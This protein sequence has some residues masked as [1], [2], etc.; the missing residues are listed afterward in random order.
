[1]SELLNKNKV[2]NTNPHSYKSHPGYEINYLI[3]AY[4]LLVLAAGIIGK[5]CVKTICGKFRNIKPNYK[6]CSFRNGRLIHDN[7]S[8]LRD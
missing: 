3:L 5:S 8:A 2:S 6:F 7:L 1:M 4:I